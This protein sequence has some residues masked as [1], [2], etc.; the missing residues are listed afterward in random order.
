M[1]RWRPTA[2]HAIRAVCI[3]HNETST[4]ITLP[5]AEIRQVIDAA[6]HPALLLADTIS[7]LGS[8][9]FR[10]DEWGVDGVVGGSQKGLMLATGL[11]FTGVSAKG[12]AAHQS[13][14][15]PKHY[16]NW[17]NM[18]G[19]RHKSFVGTVPTAP[20]YGM[21]EALR[22]IEEEGLDQV[23]ARHHRLAEAVRAC[24]R[25]WAGNNGPQLFLHRSVR[26]CRIR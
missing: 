6:R 13:S 1:R 21:R 15:L 8:I 26:G 7:S 19:R 3:V 9:D 25:R 12:M 24:V 23:L 2:T 18:I 14:K 20:F 10:M 11:G 16:F 22:I 17:S 4:G 5:L